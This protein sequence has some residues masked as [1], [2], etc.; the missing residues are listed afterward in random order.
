[1]IKRVRRQFILITMTMLTAVLLIPLVA[2]NVVTQTV[3]YQQTAD[4]LQQIAEIEAEA[5]EE[6]YDNDSPDEPPTPKETKAE[7]KNDSSEDDDEEDNEDKETKQDETDETTLPE[8]NNA[9]QTVVKTTTNTGTLLEESSKETKPA[10]STKLTEEANTTAPKNT[11]PAKTTTATTKAMTK[12]P[13]KLAS[14]SAKQTYTTAANHTEP[15]FPYDE[16]DR[17]DADWNLVQSR[18]TYTS[19]DEYLEETQTDGLADLVLLTEMQTTTTAKTTTTATTKSS[20]PDSTKTTSTTKRKSDNSPELEKPSNSHTSTISINHF[21]IYSDLDGILLKLEGTDDYTEE[22]AQEML[23]VILVS[24]EETDYYGNLQYYKMKMKYGTLVVFTD[25]ASA[26]MLLRNIF[27]IS[28]VTFFIMEIVVLLL[29]LYLTKRSMQ[30]IY[31][32]FERQRQFISD[33]GHELKTPLTI[34]SANVDILEDEIGE[35]KWLSYIRSQTERMRILVGDMMNLTKVELDDTRRNFKQ[36][37]LSN[38]VSSAALPFES[39]AFEMNKKLELDIQ[40]NIL[41]TGDAEEIKRLVGIFIDNAI[42]YSDEKGEIR[43]TLQQIKDKCTLKFYNTGK[44]VTEDEKEKIF[45]RF[46]RSDA[47]RTRAT[48][49]YGLG[50]SIAKSICDAHRIKIHVESEYGR[51]VCFVL[52]L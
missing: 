51:W 35:N 43:V 16:G 44:G 52:T 2:I 38:V 33:A 5:W 18:W 25:C 7:E 19:W 50:L 1:M 21:S 48:G 45:E 20:K 28:I 14:T 27:W 22:E 4:N 40:E 15:V 49:G 13:T 39:Q 34:I 23:D 9:T 31:A 8:S 42:K 26:Q 6:D 11:E 32:A 17:Q 47:S 29:S 12:E 41:Y 37:S 36:F 46:Y 3:C 24:D 30:P 10:Q